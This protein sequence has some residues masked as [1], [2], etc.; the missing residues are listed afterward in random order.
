[1]RQEPP[2]IFFVCGCLLSPGINPEAH[3][4][5]GESQLPEKAQPTTKGLENGKELRLELRGIN[6]TV[7]E[8]LYNQPK[9]RQRMRIHPP[10]IDCLP[11]P[12]TK[13]MHASSYYSTALSE[14]GSRVG[15][16]IAIV[17]VF[18]LVAALLYFAR[19]TIIRFVMA[20]LV[21]QREARGEG[22]TDA[23]VDNGGAKRPG[24]V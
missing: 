10:T 13:H 23:T 5:I 3:W 20:L 12:V 16:A 4:A 6:I 22:S 18:G 1:M 7:S 24:D 11:S 14:M 9:P 17:A 2:T 8:A 21:R 19:Q 15:I